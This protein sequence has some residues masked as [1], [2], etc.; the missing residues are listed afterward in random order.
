ML[1][2]EKKIAAVGKKNG[3]IFLVLYFVAFI[4]AYILS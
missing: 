4:K 3:N 1:F 2:L